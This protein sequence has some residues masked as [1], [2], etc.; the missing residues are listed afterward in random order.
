MANQKQAAR[1]AA[2][3]EAAKKASQKQKEKRFMLIGAVAVLSIAAVV[4]LLVNLFALNLSSITLMLT[5]GLVS[6]GLY[7]AKGGQKA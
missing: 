3:A 1:A 5:A 7:L 2:A 6:L 4:M